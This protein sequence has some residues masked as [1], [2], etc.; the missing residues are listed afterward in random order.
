MTD[1]PRTS[2]ERPIICRGRP[3]LELWNICFFSVKIRN[4]CVKQGL[5]H[6]KNNFSIKSSFFVLVPE[7]SL[8]VPDV[9]T[10]R[11]PSGNVPGTSRAGWV[12]AYEYQKN[13]QVQKKL[14]A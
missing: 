6:L 13:K 14:I 11:G 1:V 9:R 5:L 2:P 8:E 7:G 10:F 12:V 4:R 3:Q